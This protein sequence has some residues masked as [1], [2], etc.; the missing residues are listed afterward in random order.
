LLDQA[1]QRLRDWG[2]SEIIM[3][4]RP[5]NQVAVGMYTRRGF[6]SYDRVEE[7]LLPA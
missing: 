5:E 1:I 4:V 3:Q 7:L 6:V 2:A